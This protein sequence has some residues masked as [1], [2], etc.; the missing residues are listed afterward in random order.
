MISFYSIGKIAANHASVLGVLEMK[1]QPD[2]PQFWLTHY[3]L[4]AQWIGAILDKSQN[5]NLLG[6]M[7]FCF[8]PCN[9]SIN[10]KKAFY[11]H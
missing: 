4:A 3:I 9:V 10:I 5:W 1:E 2:I 8:C 7:H 6:F 11:T